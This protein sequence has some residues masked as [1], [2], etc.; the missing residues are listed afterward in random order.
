MKT[1]NYLMMAALAA[2]MS[3][4]C[5]AFT[6]CS[7]NDNPVP[8]DVLDG[9]GGTIPGE[10]IV[11][12]GMLVINN[13]SSSMGIDGSLTF[14]DLSLDQFVE[15][16]NVYKNAN[17]ES[18]GG[19]PNDVLVY[20]N[21]IYI[22]G[23]DGN[24]VFV[25][26]VRTFKEIKKISVDDE[27]CIN[28]RHLI[29]YGKKVYVS[30]YDGYVCALDT[31]SLEIDNKYKV[32][33]CPEGMTISETTATDVSLYVANSD[34]GNGDGSISKINLTT[35]S[36]TEIKIDKIRYPQQLAVVE[37]D[38]YV[39][40]GGYFDEN[41]LQKDAGVYKIH[42]NDAS[43]VVPDATGMVVAGGT[44]ITYNYPYGC[45]KPTYSVYYMYSDSLGTFLPTGDNGNPI[46]SPCAI[47][48]DHNM[49]YVY[50]ASR[51]MD[52]DTGYPSYSYPGYV[53]AYNFDGQF[54]GSVP[55]GV[56]PCAFAFIYGTSKYVSRADRSA[57]R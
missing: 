23:S 42:G 20:G 11:T 15:R 51:M 5:V 37:D 29:A 40:D 56:E 19:S 34:N 47:G 26:D 6:S 16:Q 55:V 25:L 35:G 43:M 49:G 38:I 13:G 50:I 48:F 24:T 1:K 12:K 10:F 3:M 44:I 31:F 22:A 52:S 45:D 4:T 8:S 14:V 36:V 32:G 28:P 41:Y 54:V 53:N 9:D 46:Q 18:L 7:T 27:G 21:K 33:S 17:G 2:V 39:L 57:V 30:T